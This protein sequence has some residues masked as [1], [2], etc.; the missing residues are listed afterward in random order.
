MSASLAELIHILIS[1][2]NR[3]F[4]EEREHGTVMFETKWNS[5][6]KNKFERGQEQ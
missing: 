1:G 5:D 2:K 6:K 4:A 3:V